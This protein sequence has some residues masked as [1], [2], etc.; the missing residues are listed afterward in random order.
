MQIVRLTPYPLPI[1]DILCVK[2]TLEVDRKKITANKMLS[3]RK[4]AVYFK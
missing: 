1:P 2:Y 3:L 4:H